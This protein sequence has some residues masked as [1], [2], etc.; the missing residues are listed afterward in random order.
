MGKDKRG[1]FT[2]GNNYAKRGWLGLV[3]KR[4]NGDMGAA[5]AWVGAI[6]AWAADLPYADLFP[7]FPHPGTPEEFK[8]QRDQTLAGIS[9]GNVEE[10][11]Y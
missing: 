6:G 9:L 3:E 2:R 4:F 11:A 7:A 8:Q 10:L 5:R 1:R